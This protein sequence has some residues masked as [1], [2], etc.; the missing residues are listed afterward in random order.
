M[1][2]LLLGDS[3]RTV[4]GGDHS[5]LRIKPHHDFCVINPAPHLHAALHGLQ[6]ETKSIMSALFGE[7]RID[8]PI[9]YSVTGKLN[10]IAFG[11]VVRSGRGAPIG[12]GNDRCPVESGDVVLFDLGQVGHVAPNGQYMLLWRNILAVLRPDN[13]YP[14]PC[15]NWVLTKRDDQ[16]QDRFVFSKS[17]GKLVMPRAGAGVVKTNDRKRSRVGVAVDRVLR[18]GMGRYVKKAFEAIECQTGDVVAFMPTQSIDL[19]W[20]RG[21]LLRF[22]AWS[23]I[24]FTVE[25]IG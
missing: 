18:V 3:S 22:T 10:Q 25:G 8:S 23:E 6:L 20:R 5:G 16:L 1:S 24:L 11:I 17:G 15:L 7:V 2:A 19:A 12:P 13:E 4:R 9:K 14:D 21:E